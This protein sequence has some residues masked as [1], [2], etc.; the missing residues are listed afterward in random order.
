MFWRLVLAHLLGDYPLQS[1]WMVE[2]KAN[3]RGIGLHMASHCLSMVVLV[4]PARSEIWPQLLVITLMHLLLDMTKTSLSR[5]W[6]KRI[7]LQYLADQIL[8]I[9]TIYL[10]TLWIEGIVQ[11]DLLP[12]DTRWTILAIAYLLVTYVWHITERTIAGADTVY[13]GELQDQFWGRMTARAV[14][15]TL[16]LVVRPGLGAFGLAIM[17]PYREGIYRRR[18]LTID[19][20][21]ALSMAVFINLAA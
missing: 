9:S 8:H 4:G 16:F 20:V 2:N 17:L 12:S 10:V 5:L 3:V 13:Q 6:P 1:D 7:V 11:P 19:I 18:A 21:V 14:M 15:L